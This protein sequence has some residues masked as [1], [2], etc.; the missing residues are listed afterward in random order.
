MRGESPPDLAEAMLT[1]S[2]LLVRAGR[3]DLAALEV[4]PGL[5]PHGRR[6]GMV[7]LFGGFAAIDLYG[8]SGNLDGLAGRPRHPGRRA[9]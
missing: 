7:A 6:E 4:L 3:G 9:R 8:D 1:A 2:G 5:A